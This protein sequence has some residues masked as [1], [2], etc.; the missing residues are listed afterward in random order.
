[1][2][3][4][5]DT[6]EL[7]ERP[8]HRKVIGVKWVH[9][10]KLNFDGSINKVKARLVAKGYAQE[11]GVDYTDTFALVARHDTIRILIVFAT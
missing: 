6:W 4:R 3:E 11:V 5:N 9:K 2:I 1:M 8:P 10:T 7:V